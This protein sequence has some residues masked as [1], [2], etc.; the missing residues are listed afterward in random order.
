MTLITLALLGS[1][2]AYAQ[3]ATI[4][5][6]VTDPS[7]AVVPQATVTA[8]SADTGVSS[9]TE[10]TSEGYYTLSTLQ[11]GRYELTVAKQAFVPVRQTGL[12]LTVQQVARLDSALQPSVAVGTV[13]VAEQ[14]PLLASE[15]STDG[16][17]IGDRRVTEAALLRRNTYALAML[18]PGVRPSAGGQ[19]LGID[20]A[21]SVSCPD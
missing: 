6:R 18:Q 14:T 15:R 12:E 1:A 10:T 3:V 13:A 4:T 5:G 8:K 21:S 2:A 19:R 16:Q 17:V 7:G 9:V 11:P 20:E